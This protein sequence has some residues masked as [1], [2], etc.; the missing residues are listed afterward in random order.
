MLADRRVQFL[1][2]QTAFC[3]LAF[4]SGLRF[5][6]H[7][8]VPLAAA[9]FA[10]LVQAIWHL[11]R[12][13]SRTPGRDWP[14]SCRRSICDNLVT[15]AESKIMRNRIYLANDII[16]NELM[17]KKFKGRFLIVGVLVGIIVTKILLQFR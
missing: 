14:I 12:L 7:Y 6:A 11:R 9:L 1:I 5:Q 8:A 15:H 13:I 2:T 17:P 4:L 10:L 3:F 16:L